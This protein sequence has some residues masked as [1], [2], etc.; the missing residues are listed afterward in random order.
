MFLHGP[1]SA[2][3]RVRIPLGSL[4]PP[5][6]QGFRGIF[7][8]LQGRYLTV[9]ARFESIHSTLRVANMEVTLTVEN[10]DGEQGNVSAVGDDYT[11]ALTKARALIPEDCKAIVIRADS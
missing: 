2:V 10:G 6:T 5:E 4:N 3:T 7:C 9:T 8:W 11:D 1:L